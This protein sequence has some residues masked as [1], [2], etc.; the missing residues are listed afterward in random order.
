MLLDFHF[1]LSNAVAQPLVYL[2]RLAHPPLLLMLALQGPTIVVTSKRWV[3]YPAL[4]IL[5]VLATFHMPFA[6]NKMLARESFQYLLIYYAL[7]LATAVYIKSPRQA[8]PILA[9]LVGQ[10]AWYAVFSGTTGRVMWHPT[11]ANFDGYGNLMVQGAAL[12]YWFAVAARGRKLK[13]FLYG[14][15]SYC[16]LGVVASYA[17][18]AFLSL[19]CIVGWIWV[20]SPR[21]IATAAGIAV[22]CIMIVVGASL[23]FEPGFFYNEMMSAFEEGTEQGTGEQRWELWK[24]AI[25][26]WMQH[27]IIGVG[28]GN[29]GSYS[30]SHFKFGELEAFPNPGVL[31][32]FN[33]HN[34]YMQVLSEFGLVGVFAFGW[35]VWDF[36]KRNRELR[37]P[38]AIQRWA[39]TSGGTWNLRYL[40]L[41]LEAANL[42]N[43][44][45]AMFY[46]SLFMP[47]FFTIWAAN[48]ML[49]AV[50]RA[51]SEEKPARRSRV[52]RPTTPVGREPPAA[53]VTNPP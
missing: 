19:V 18:A 29:F 53:P 47:A 25:Q 30:A 14:L 34:G 17:R 6:T 38:G 22:A 23:I 16:V 11:L 43:M 36:V 3:L 8:L 10:F 35:A 20:R 52:W 37:E 24:V 48:R 44:L 31:Y 13:L 1:F 15:A 42:A 49:W 51:P 7:A 2:V 40:S 39:E 50:T 21:K 41:G 9:L 4:L 28:G 32:G 46:A 33:L 26:V 12:T 27:P 5:L 45:G